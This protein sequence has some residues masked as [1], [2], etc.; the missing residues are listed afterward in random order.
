MNGE[1]F[2]HFFM[3]SSYLTQI[4]DSSSIPSLYQMF[5]RIDLL[6]IL[7]LDIVWRLGGSHPQLVLIQG[8]TNDKW[9]SEI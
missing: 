9:K 5:S 6:R 7:E 3:A 8:D 2:D 4:R 1:S